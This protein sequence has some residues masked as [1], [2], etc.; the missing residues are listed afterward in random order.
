MAKHAPNRDNALKLMEFLS[1][2]KAQRLYGSANFEYPVKPGVGPDARTS[3]WGTLKADELPLSEI[4]KH[5][6]SASELV[7]KVGF[8]NGPQS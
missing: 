8:N 4:A 1:S 6:K 7:D 2:A 5:R 3:S